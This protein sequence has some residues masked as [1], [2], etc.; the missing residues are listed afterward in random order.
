MEDIRGSTAMLMVA[1]ILEEWHSRRRPKLPSRNLQPETT[2]R[3]QERNLHHQELHLCRDPGWSY[4]GVNQREEAGIGDL[5]IHSN[6]R[7]P[8]LMRVRL[9]LKPDQFDGAN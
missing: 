4:H 5:L 6:A 3:C 1:P 9:D 8:Q 2:S 7:N